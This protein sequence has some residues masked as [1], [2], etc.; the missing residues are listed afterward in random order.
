MWLSDVIERLILADF[1]TPHPHL[2]LGRM[3]SMLINNPVDLKW[4][5]TEVIHFCAVS[6]CD[7]A[8][9]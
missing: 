4:L 1:N 9:V 2:L 8:E 7:P 3:S 6:A 5:F